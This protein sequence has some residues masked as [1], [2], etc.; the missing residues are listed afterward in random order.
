[1]GIY[2]PLPSSPIYPHTYISL[3]RRKRRERE[4]EEE[5]EEEGKERERKRERDVVEVWLN[6]YIR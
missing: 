2:L 6:L 1:M 5:E 4:E 3:Y